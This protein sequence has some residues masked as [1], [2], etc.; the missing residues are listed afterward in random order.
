[1]HMYRTTISGCSLWLCVYGKWIQVHIKVIF[2]FVAVSKVFLLDRN[3]HHLRALKGAL[4]ELQDLHFVL[5]KKITKSRDLPYV[6]TSC[7]EFTRQ[8]KFQNHTINHVFRSVKQ[9]GSRKNRHKSTHF[10]D[11]LS[12][13]LPVPVLFRIRKILAMIYK[14]SLLL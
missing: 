1:M 11:D 4:A 8:E 3:C 10:C 2:M 9:K 6:R 13:T 7:F 14:L 5:R 12:W